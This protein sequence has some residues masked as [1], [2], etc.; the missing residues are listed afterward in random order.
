MAGDN[1]NHCAYVELRSPIGRR[2]V[3]KKL[4]M[5]ILPTISRLV[6]I[7][8]GNSYEFRWNPSADDVTEEILITW[9]AGEW[10]SV[11]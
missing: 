2:R 7:V 1:P 6:L 9:D 4:I 11:M 5:K 10:A 8:H 3:A